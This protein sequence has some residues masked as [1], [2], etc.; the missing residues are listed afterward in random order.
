MSSNEAIL[1]EQNKILKKQ[2]EIL[3]QIS[4]QNQA[5]CKFEKI[6]A[7]A[8]VVIAASVYDH[9]TEESIMDRIE[10]AITNIQDMLEPIYND[11]LIDSSF[12]E[13]EEGKDEDYLSLQ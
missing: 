4:K 3:E 12:V 5:R 7:D 11:S 13:K 8:L 1:E 2:N 9:K 6:T 10:D